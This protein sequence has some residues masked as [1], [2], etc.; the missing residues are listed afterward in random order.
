MDSYQSDKHAESGCLSDAHTL[1]HEPN[2]YGSLQCCIEASLLTQVVENKP[3]VP[4][5]MMKFPANRL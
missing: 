5:P 2:K 3:H 1:C 4:F